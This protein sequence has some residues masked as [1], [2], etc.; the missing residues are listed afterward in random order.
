MRL[1]KGKESKASSPEDQR[2]SG[3]A[4]IN[5]LWTDRDKARGG[6]Q[7]ANPPTVHP[8]HAGG[9]APQTAAQTPKLEIPTPCVSGSLSLRNT[10]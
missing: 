2:L 8:V 3:W 9:S 6:G 1:D 7:E 5:S 4:S 10:A